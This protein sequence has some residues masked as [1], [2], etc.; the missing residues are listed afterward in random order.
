MIVTLKR[1]EAKIR[2]SQAD[3]ADYLTTPEHVVKWRYTA[4]G[5]SPLGGATAADGFCVRYAPAKKE[6]YTEEY[7]IV[8]KSEERVNIETRARGITYT[9]QYDFAKSGTRTRVTCSLTRQVSALQ[10]PLTVFPLRWFWLGYTKAL[11]KFN[12]LRLSAALETR[13]PRVTK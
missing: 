9:E 10:M 6:P 1:A 11:F 5:T 3:V 7:R 2:A 8:A 12:L 13:P 4:T